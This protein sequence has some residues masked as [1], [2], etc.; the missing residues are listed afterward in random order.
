[1]RHLFSLS[2]HHTAIILKWMKG[3]GKGEHWKPIAAD[4][5]R[6]TGEIKRRKERKSMDRTFHRL[7]RRSF[8]ITLQN[9]ALRMYTSNAR[10]STDN[11]RYVSLSFT[12]CSFFHS[13]SNR[14]FTRAVAFYQWPR[15]TYAAKYYRF[16]SEDLTGQGGR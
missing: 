16:Q 4:A 1:M 10:S 8:F 14:R 6:K 2:F 7:L 9:S 12:V 5:H 11:I 3:G 13:N 15:R